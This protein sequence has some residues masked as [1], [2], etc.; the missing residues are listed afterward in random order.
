MAAPTLPRHWELLSCDDQAKYLALQ[1]SLATPSQKNRR[2]RSVDTFPQTLETIKS[3]VNR[4]DG[5]DWKRSVV[6]GV[7]WLNS[8]GTVALNIRQLR[9]LVSKCKSSINGSFQ[10]LG[11]DLVSAGMECSISLG[12]YLPVLHDN[13][14]ELRQ[15]TIRKN[16]ATETNG[17]HST[18]SCISP[19]PEGEGV[20]NVCGSELCVDIEGC[21][22]FFSEIIQSPSDALFER[23]YEMNVFEDPLSFSPRDMEVNYEELSYFKFEESYDPHRKS[24]EGF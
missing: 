1:Q 10:F 6:C 19:A 5:D 15:W 9:V 18:P 17:H 4:N 16:A 23:R 24:S 8:E 2:N 20:G 11:F 21:L 14:Q 3:F 13:F 12:K 7:C 22:S